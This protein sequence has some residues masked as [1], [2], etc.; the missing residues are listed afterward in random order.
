MV[1][2]VK[3]EVLFIPIFHYSHFYGDAFYKTPAKRWLKNIRH[4]KVNKFP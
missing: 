1:K 4:A 3:K 2:G